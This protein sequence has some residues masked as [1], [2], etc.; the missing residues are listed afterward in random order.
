MLPA[1]ASHHPAALVAVGPVAAPSSSSSSLDCTPSSSSRRCHRVSPV[2]PLLVAVAS[3]ARS[4]SVSPLPLLPLVHP[5]FAWLPRA[6]PGRPPLLACAAGRLL[7]PAPALTAAPAPALAPRASALALLAPATP[8]L[9]L[10]RP[11]SGV[12]PGHVAPELCS[13]TTSHHRASTASLA[14]TRAV[15]TARAR[16]RRARRPTA[17]MAARRLAVV[18]LRASPPPSVLDTVSPFCS[19]CRRG[20]RP[21]GGHGPARPAP[22]TAPGCPMPGAR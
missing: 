18:A 9:C 1:V 6:R 21:P 14:G 17:P 2:V 7:T 15:P 13:T 16:S 12:R 4:R 22:V 3:H 20:R 5:R 11:M 8:G 10:H 19:G